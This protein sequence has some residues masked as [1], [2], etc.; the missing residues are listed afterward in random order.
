MLVGLQEQRGM[1]HDPLS[2]GRVRGPPRA[3]E[4]PHL[5]VSG[6]CIA[7]IRGEPFRLSAIAARQR[8]EVLLCRVG[9]DQ[10]LSNGLLDLLGELLDQ[11]QSPRHPARR[12]LEQS[13]QIL[14]PKLEL[15][16]QLA[17][18]PS[19]FE[20][21][22]LAVRL[23]AVREGERVRLAEG[24]DDGLDHVV[25]ELPHGREATMT[26]DQDE[27]LAA[28]DDQNGLLL[29][30]SADRREESRLT[31][32][33]RDAERGVGEVDAMQLDLDGHAAPYGGARASAV[34][35]RGVVR[36][37][38]PDFVPPTCIFG[39]TPCRASDRITFASSSMT[40]ATSTPTA[41][42]TTETSSAAIGSRTAT[43][44]VSGGTAGRPFRRR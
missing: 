2:G 28:R 20:R 16:D 9:A 32:R 36:G 30:F 8:D 38:F 40:T 26:V 29:A 34:S 31:S 14:L 11:R 5:S 42:R 12:T 17:Q 27:A 7:E 25:A 19:V 39:T 10:A 22:T 13:R 35:C 24:E 33:I 6:A 21:R 37:T 1:I 18:E 44:D 15:L 43:S 4:A 3:V 41:C 23:D